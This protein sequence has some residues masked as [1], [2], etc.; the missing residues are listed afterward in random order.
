[1][2]SKRPRWLNADPRRPCA[3]IFWAG[4][5]SFNDSPC[6]PL[7]L[8]NGPG[9]K[10]QFSLSALLKVKWATFFALGSRELRNLLAA[11]A[12]SDAGS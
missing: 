10:C 6:L 1:M 4:L 9:K 7:G 8:I 3:R 5:M 2:V 11:A 12:I